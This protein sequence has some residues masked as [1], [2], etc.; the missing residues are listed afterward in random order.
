M[1]TSKSL[2][3]KVALAAAFALVPALASAH[4]GHPGHDQSSFTSGLL[5]PVLGMDH[6]LAMV[7]VGLWAMQLGGRA[8]WAVPATFV[9]V[10]LLGGFAGVGGFVVPYLEQGI[11]ASVLI[12]GLL[13]VMA[14]RVPMVASMGLVAAFA[15]LHGVAHGA[16]MPVGANGL[17]YGAGFAATTVVLHGCGLLGGDLLRNAAQAA[18]LRAAGVAVLTGGFLL[19]LS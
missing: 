17:A 3:S 15:L 19:A 16:E 18:W 7:A 12:L 13:I 1:T 9:S 10:M 5:H 6:L 8:R 2:F 4:P 14:A 11:L